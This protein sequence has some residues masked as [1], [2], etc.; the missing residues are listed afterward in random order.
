[1]TV[2]LK[3]S[4][5]RALNRQ[6]KHRNTNQNTTAAILWA[7]VSLSS[8]LKL[9]NFG[10]SFANLIN[11]HSCY[12]INAQPTTQTEDGKPVLRSDPSIS[13]SRRLLQHWNSTTEFQGH[14]FSL[15][16][17]HKLQPLLN[18]AEYLLRFK[19]FWQIYLPTHSLSTTLEAKV[20]AF[21]TILAW[22]PGPADGFDRRFPPRK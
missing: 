14:S 4:L 9:L 7:F 3:T 12:N 8:V 5:S 21:A 18:K 6:N 13:R 11:R 17:N 19:F 15:F 2:L 10:F 22:F 16:N 1:M 20:K